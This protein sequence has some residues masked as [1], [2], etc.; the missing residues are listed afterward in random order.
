ME[1]SGQIYVQNILEIEIIGYVDALDVGIKEREEL[2]MIPRFWLKQWMNS[3]V[4]SRGGEVRG[5]TDEWVERIK[6]LLAHS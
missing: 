6:Y 3:D 1:A 4:I 2:R 5:G